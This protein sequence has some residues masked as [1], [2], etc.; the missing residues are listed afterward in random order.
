[1]PRGE[2]LDRDRPPREEL[3]KRWGLTPFR[4]GEGGRRIY[5]RAREE[6]LRA[7]EALPPPVRGKVIRLG[8]EALKEVADAQEGEQ[9]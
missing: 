2:N 6:D 1:M 3:A 7:L 5:I 9:A 4:P 8:L